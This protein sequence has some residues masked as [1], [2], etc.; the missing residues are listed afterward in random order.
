MH[1]ASSIAAVSPV[2]TFMIVDLAFGVRC[3]ETPAAVSCPKQSIEPHR[4]NGSTAAMD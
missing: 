4:S 2:P 1:R 3:R